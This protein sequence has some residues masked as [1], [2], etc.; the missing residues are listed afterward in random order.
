MDLPG[1]DDF[2]VLAKHYEKQ[3]IPWRL[4]KKLPFIHNWIYIYIP[5][6]QLTSIF[7]GQPSKRKPFFNQNKGH[8]GSRYISIKRITQ[9]VP[10]V[11]A[12]STAMGYFCPVNNGMKLPTSTGDSRISSFNSNTGQ[13]RQNYH[14]FT[15]FDSPTMGGIEW[16]L[17]E[18]KD[19]L[20]K[21]NRHSP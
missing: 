8:L 2:F 15:L 9:L 6:T 18:N 14:T 1:S 7:E 11:L 20:P 17:L 13:I 12:I 19:T 21:T 4:N 5:R 16:P 10:R 3:W